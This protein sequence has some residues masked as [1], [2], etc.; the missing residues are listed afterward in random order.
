MGK[1]LVSGASGNVGR[2]VVKYAL[3]AGQKVKA[4]GT[5]DKRLAQLFPDAEAVLF[6][7]T[8]PSTFPSALQ[9][10]D[11]VFI[12]RPPHLGNPKDLKPFIDALQKQKSIRL[13]SFLS[14]MG[15]EKNPVPPHHKIERYIEQ[16]GLRSCL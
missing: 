15:V 14:L 11:R 10:V 8:K 6:D 9:D 1:I 7:F 4:A 13:V 5:D 12:M 3:A 16:A 2:Y